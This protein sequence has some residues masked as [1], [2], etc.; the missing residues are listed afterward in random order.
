M[1]TMI[2][3]KPIDPEGVPLDTPIE[4]FVG[5]IPGDPM[6]SVRVAGLVTRDGDTG[7]SYYVMCTVRIRDTAEGHGLS[8]RAVAAVAMIANASRQMSMILDIFGPD[9]FD[10]DASSESAP[11]S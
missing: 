7:Y 5:E 10:V 4:I 9:A 6:G 11:K 8:S 2:N 3:V 1:T